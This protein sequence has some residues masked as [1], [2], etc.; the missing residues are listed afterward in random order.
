MPHLTLEY[1]DNLPAGLDLRSILGRLHRVVASEPVFALPEV[2]SR[3]VPHGVFLV[4]GGAPEAIFV[5]LTVAILDGRDLEL[6]Q[7][8]SR[9][10]LGALREEFSMAYAERPCDLT[11][12]IREMERAS[13][14]KAMN[15][16]S[17][18][19]AEPAP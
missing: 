6:R 19:P 9:Q 8:L 12:E 7:R 18:T 14:A 15:D 2:K 11:V 1:S 16:R 3:A 17:N 13:Y 10:L 5:H 4:G